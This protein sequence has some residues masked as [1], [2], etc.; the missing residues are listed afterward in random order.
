MSASVS[1]VHKIYTIKKPLLS[2]PLYSLDINE[3]LKKK[4]YIQ[5]SINSQDWLYLFLINLMLNTGHSSIYYHGI[6]FMYLD[7]LPRLISY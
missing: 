6:H 4:L 3:K 2:V 7:L 5:Y 1:H